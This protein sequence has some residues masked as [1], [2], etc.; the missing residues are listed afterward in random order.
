MDWLPRQKRDRQRERQRERT[1]DFQGHNHEIQGDNREIG[2]Q[3]ISRARADG[4][5]CLMIVSSRKGLAAGLQFECIA[6][7]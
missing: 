2:L 3:S 6:L 4:R 5:P 1:I 7:N